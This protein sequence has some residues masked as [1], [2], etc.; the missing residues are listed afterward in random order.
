MS[1]YCAMAKLTV[2]QHSTVWNSN[3]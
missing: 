2:G 3:V 1:S